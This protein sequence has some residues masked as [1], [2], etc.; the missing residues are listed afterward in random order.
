MSTSFTARWNESAID[1]NYEKWRK[2]AASV[3]ADW[4]S[5]FEGFELGYARY[6]KAPAKP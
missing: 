5:F 4:A 2:D 3:S 1:E 6:Q